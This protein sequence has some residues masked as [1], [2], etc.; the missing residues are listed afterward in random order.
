MKV[1]LITLA[2]LLTACYT[3]I[4]ECDHGNRV[5]RNDSGGLAVVPNDASCKEVA[6]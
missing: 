1:V 3:P 2:L 4:S 6:K 5:Y